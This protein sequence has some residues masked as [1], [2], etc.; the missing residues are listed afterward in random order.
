MLIQEAT[1]FSNLVRL[2]LEM[3][4]LTYEH[5]AG[6]DVSRMGTLALINIPKKICT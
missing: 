3:V 1:D 6:E 4:F 5:F 2:H